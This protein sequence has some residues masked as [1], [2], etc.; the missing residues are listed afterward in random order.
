M[1]ESVG[2]CKAIVP[3]LFGDLSWDT[4]ISTSIHFFAV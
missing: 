2:F 3:L 4:A 1:A